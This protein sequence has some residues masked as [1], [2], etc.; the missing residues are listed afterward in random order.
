MVLLNDRISPVPSQNVVNGRAQMMYC[1][2]T[3]SST[4]KM[5]PNILR[6]CTESKTWGERWQF[7]VDGSTADAQSGVIIS[8]DTY[9]K[10]TLAVSDIRREEFRKRLFVYV[11]SLFLP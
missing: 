4:T 6:R 7:D 2:A 10:H 1:G 8:C 3:C 5:R 11:I 9:V